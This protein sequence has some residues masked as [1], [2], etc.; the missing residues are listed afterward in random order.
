MLATF[1]FAAPILVGSV[2]FDDMYRA[3]VMRY[4]NQEQN[5]MTKP[6]LKPKQEDKQVDSLRK[7]I[8]RNQFSNKR[9]IPRKTQPKPFSENKFANPA[10]VYDCY[11]DVVNQIRC[12]IL[13]NECSCSYF[14]NFFKRQNDFKNQLYYD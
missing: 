13:S 8:K 3:M 7:H 12:Q 10:K 2:E 4:I 11:I 5:Y 1:L 6:W 9:A 14:I